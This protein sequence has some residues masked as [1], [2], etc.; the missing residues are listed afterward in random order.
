MPEFHCNL[1]QTGD[2]LRHVWSHTI[3]SD[4]ARMALRADWREQ[5]RRVREELGV[6]YVRFH[7]LLD[8]DMA[9][10]LDEQDTLH[11]GFHNADLI[12]DF[13]REIGMRP[14]VELS[15]MPTALASGHTTVFSYR[16]NVTPPKKLADWEALIDRLLRHWVDRYGLDEVRRWYFEV[17]NEPNISSFWTGTQA[18][19]FELYRHTATTIKSVDAQLQVGGPATA[20][21]EWI[22]DFVA[23]CRRARLPC[24]F[25]STHHYPTDAF[26][27]PGDDT[28]KQLSLATRGILHRRVLDSCAAAATLPVYYTEWCSSSNPF[29]K[30]H[31]EPYAA[32][33]MIKNFLA[34]AD[35]VQC[36]SWWTFSDI[37]AENYFSSVPFHGGFG[38]LTI[39]GI[40]KPTYRA[41]QMLH[42]LGHERLRVDGAHVTV[43][44]AVV[45]GEGV[46]MVLLSNHAFPEHPIA[47]E[48]VTIELACSQPPT[49][50][51]LERIDEDH[52]NPR[53]LWE[54]LGSPDY[55]NAEQ[56]HRL[57][58]AALLQREPLRWHA[59]TGGFSLNID[60]PPHAVAAI[61]LHVPNDDSTG[62]SS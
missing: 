55:P 29:F 22:A 40:P 20:N 52:C 8:D 48:K 12:I 49:G 25:V 53:K 7:G 13:L 44:A 37:F 62:E 6:E 34:V 39:D 18:D 1:D 21:D 42:R 27:K 57:N 32:A 36:Y 59:K 17:W 58:E 31:D 60:L 23:F 54:E 28:E 14:F 38:L 3:G 2:L 35:L 51:W 47:A 50:A 61:T 11:Y 46:V 56:Q 15:F 26:G 41:F 16:G 45:R 9:I 24:D 43:D 10:L 4:H 30:L 33:F 5:M 19:Y